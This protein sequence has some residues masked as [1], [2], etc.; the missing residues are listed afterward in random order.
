MAILEKELLMF[1][2]ENIRGEKMVNLND[3][4]FVFNTSYIDDEL[5]VQRVHVIFRNGEP[6]YKLISVKKDYE[7]DRKYYEFLFTDKGVIKGNSHLFCNELT[8]DSTEFIT[9]GYKYCSESSILT[10]LDENGNDGRNCQL[11][12]GKFYS[13]EN[14]DSRA[15]YDPESDK[16]YYLNSFTRHEIDINRDVKE[17][18]WNAKNEDREC[19]NQIISN[20]IEYV[21]KVL[22]EKGS[23]YNNY[24]IVTWL[25]EENK[26][27]VVSW[28]GHAYDY[29][30]REYLK[31]IKDFYQK[32]LEFRD[33]IVPRFENEIQEFNDELNDSL[34]CEKRL[35]LVLDNK[36]HGR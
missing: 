21:K 1:I 10:K 29:T 9:E 31:I 4:L 16:C 19:K 18:I 11:I 30:T 36:K 20:L 22:D 8:N 15:M 6:V 24:D 2:D 12:D 27:P 17:Q 28:N 33:E 26:L 32:Y 7:H 5:L 13:P 14:P 3:E 25:D 35:N 23:N 34:T